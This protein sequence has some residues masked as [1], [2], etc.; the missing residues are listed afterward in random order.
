VCSSDLI[1]ETAKA[2]SIASDF[3]VEPKSEHSLTSTNKQTEQ[4]IEITNGLAS[5]SPVAGTASTADNDIIVPADQIAKTDELKKEEKDNTFKE[6][7]TQALPEAVLAKKR[8]TEQRTETYNMASKSAAPKVS[9]PIYK[10]KDKEKI[11]LQDEP[12]SLNN[13]ISNGDIEVYPL[14]DKKPEFPGGKEALLK[15]VQT[16]IQFPA[17]DDKGKPYRSVQIQFIVSASG[18]ANDPKLLKPQSKVLEKQVVE[19]VN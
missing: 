10:E 3:S 4:N 8:N 12:Y 17:T 9:E 1:E 15:Y 14:V 5:T 18:K 16:T 13:T 11:S 6:T 7:E 2:D 19:M